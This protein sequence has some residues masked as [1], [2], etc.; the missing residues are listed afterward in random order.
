MKIDKSAEIGGVCRLEGS[1][2]F[3]GRVGAAFKN[4]LPKGA[5]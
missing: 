2:P 1:G 3:F 5:E 4:F